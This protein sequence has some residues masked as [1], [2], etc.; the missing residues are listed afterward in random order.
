MR[1]D[2]FRD[3]VAIDFPSTGRF[4][5]RVRAGFMRDQRTSADDAV[6][7]EVSV[8]RHEARRGVVLPLDLSLRSTCRI[9][10]GRG[11]TWEDPCTECNSTGE[12]LVPC[13]VRVHVPPGTADGG[14]L[15]M[16]VRA[17]QATRSVRVDLRVAI[18]PL[19]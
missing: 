6:R 13:R 4:I 17:P 7:A 2:P 3:E 1:T 14:E 10:G 11:E 18:R 5:E 8:S 12:T 9:C 19:I 15:R 16:R